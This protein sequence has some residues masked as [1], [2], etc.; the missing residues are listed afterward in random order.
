MLNPESNALPARI[1]LKR[2]VLNAGGWL[3]VGYGLSLTIRLGSNLLMTRLLLP[4]M[5]GVVSMA[6]I[7]LVGLAMFSDLGLKQCIVRSERGHDAAFLNT[8]WTIQILQG[9]LLW[10]AALGVSLLVWIANVFGALPPGS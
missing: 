7:V 3:F 6:G 1:A 5:F 8:A 2:R 4:E 10:L 9:A